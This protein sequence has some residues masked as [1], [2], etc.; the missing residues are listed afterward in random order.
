M[1]VFVGR[2]LVRLSV[3]ASFY[4]ACIAVKT[5]MWNFMTYHISDECIRSEPNCKFVGSETKLNGYN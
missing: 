3:V 2:V 4:V 1:V 5:T